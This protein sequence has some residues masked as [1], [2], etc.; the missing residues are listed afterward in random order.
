MI[1]RRLK[2]S[3]FVHPAASLKFGARPNETN[4]LKRIEVAE[5]L[6]EDAHRMCREDRG[7]SLSC[8]RRTSDALRLCR[9]IHPELNPA[10]PEA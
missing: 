6:L 8:G 10:G 4:F 5:A 1:K 3:T 7:L 9:Q 2:G